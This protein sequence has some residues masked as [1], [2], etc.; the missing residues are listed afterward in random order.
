MPCGCWCRRWVCGEG[1]GGP[2]SA[3]GA[4]PARGRQQLLRRQQLLA[5]RRPFARA[6][7]AARQGPLYRDVAARAN[8]SLSVCLSQAFESRAIPGCWTKR[9]P[10]GGLAD[11]PMP[12][13]QLRCGTRRAPTPGTGGCILCPRGHPEGT[14]LI[15]AIGS[16]PIGDGPRPFLKIIRRVAPS[17][18]QL[19]PLHRFFPPP[20]AE[21]WAPRVPL[22]LPDPVCPRTA[23]RSRPRRGAPGAPQLGPNTV[24]LPK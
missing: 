5:R 1:L 23:S 12:G 3:P 19:W 13:K 15:R 7:T 14:G 6:G 21:G 9:Q 2:I 16:G 18:P 4:C 10:N 24:S 8:A 11:T 22:L 20:R 17:E